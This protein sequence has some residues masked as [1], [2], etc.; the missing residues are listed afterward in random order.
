MN[1]EK[2][3]R[4]VAAI[5]VNAVILFVI[6]VAV[7]IYQIVDIAV[8]K[9]KRDKLQTEIDYYTTETEKEGDSLE[10]YK[11]KEYL[12]DKAFEYG[13]VFGD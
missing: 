7:I 1:E 11:S 8:L 6:L 3:N 5:T 13:F 4:F 9:N 12:L 2:R 10:Y